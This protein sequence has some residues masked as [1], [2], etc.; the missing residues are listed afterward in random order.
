MKVHAQ[1]G[2]FAVCFEDT[3]GPELNLLVYLFTNITKFD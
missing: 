1:V 3:E 2:D